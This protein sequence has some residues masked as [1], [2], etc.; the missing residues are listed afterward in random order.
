MNQMYAAPTKMYEYL[1]QGKPVVAAPMPELL[2]YGDLLYLADSPDAYVACV[3]QALREDK[4]KQDHEGHV[5][6]VNRLAKT[7]G[8]IVSSHISVYRPARK[9]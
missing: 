2:P 8:R 3:E 5:G 7:P 6:S 4:Q 1:A 9:S